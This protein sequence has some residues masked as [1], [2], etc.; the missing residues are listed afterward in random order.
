M[1]EDR[2]ARLAEDLECL[3]LELVNL[4]AQLSKIRAEVAD[5]THTTGGEEEGDLVPVPIFTRPSR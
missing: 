5:L 2:L 1:L 4:E 3:G